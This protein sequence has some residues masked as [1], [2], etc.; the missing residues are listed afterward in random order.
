[1]E[2]ITIDLEK[3]REISGA[4]LKKL[5]GQK[6]L[7]FSILD[8][9]GNTVFRS[10]QAL[11]PED[12]DRETGKGKKFFIPRIAESEASFEQEIISRQTLNDLLED[13]GRTYG[14]VRKT[15]TLT[16]EQYINTNNVLISIVQGL[17]IQDKS[18]GILTLLSDIEGYDK[19]TYVH[20]VNV[21]LLSMIY[22]FKSGYSEEGIRNMATAGYLH[23]IGKLRVPVEIINKAGLLNRGEFRAI[24]EHTREG[25]RILDAVES[26]DRKKVVPNI[27]KLVALFHHRKFKNPGYPFREEQKDKRSETQYMEL[28]EEVRMIAIFDLYD[29]ITTKSPYRTA[30]ST[31]NALRYMLNISNYLYPLDDIYKFL[32]IMTLSLNK[33]RIFLQ[34]GKFIMLESVRLTSDNKRKERVYEFAR[35]EETFKGNILNP[36]VRIFYDVNRNKKLHPIG[37]DLRHDAVR[38][39]VRII[40]NTRLVDMLSKQYAH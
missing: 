3:F 10:G 6:M 8:Q 37:V 11:T 17:K 25:Y 23:D 18:G 26:S 2:E 27:I 15:G 38:K 21:G 29:A 13:T 30:I 22:A 24:M 9:E 28:P 33:G 14:E 35:V 19:H 20:S 34:D 7:N 32:K 16:F 39:I 1:M 31:E 40:N 5:S 4:Y 12:I 36:R